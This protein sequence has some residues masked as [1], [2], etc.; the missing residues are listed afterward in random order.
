MRFCRECREAA[1]AI[2]ARCRSE[3]ADASIEDRREWR[4][5]YQRAYRGTK[6][7]GRPQIVRAPRI[8]PAAMRPATPLRQIVERL[9]A[10]I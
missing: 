10:E 5:E 6:N 2:K 8:S 4:R 1:E 9:R 3:H 7:P